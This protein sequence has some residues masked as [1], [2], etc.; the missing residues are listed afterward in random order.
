MA[1]N[2]SQ[3]IDVRSKCA[4]IDYLYGPYNSVEDA[5]A[6]IVSSRRILG[7]TVGILSEE[8]ITE[9]W[10]K[11]NITDS[12]LVKKGVD[13]PSLQYTDSNPE[14][15]PI[16]KDLGDVLTI[17][18][19]FKSPNFGNCTLTVRG[20]NTVR[21]ITSPKGYIT[22][23][24]GE[25][26]TEGT[27]E[28]KITGVDSIGQGAPEELYFKVIAGGIKL[29]TNF[30][31][32]L[33]TGIN[34]SSEISMLYN[35]SI[36]DTSKTIKVHGEII[37]SEGN[38]VSNAAGN[39]LS[40]TVQGP[41]STPYVITA[42]T[43]NI[44]VIPNWGY[45]TL[46]IWAFTGNTPQDQSEDEFTTNLEYQFFLLNANDFVLS[47]SITDKTADTNTVV[48]VP[49][50]IV[51]GGEYNTLK[52]HGLLY[53]AYYNPSTGRW[54]IVDEASP[55]DGYELNSRYP[56]NTTN[57]WALGKIEQAGDYIIKM[58]AT[59]VE[60]S[61]SPIEHE[62]VEIHTRI[63][64]YITVYDYVQDGLIGDFRADG[65]SNANPADKN[66]IW[67]N[68]VANSNL[69][70]RLYGLN[71]T[72][73]GW[74]NVDETKA[75]SEEGEK[76]LKFTGES[77]GVLMNG[78]SMYNPLSQINSLDGF[79]AEIV[80]RTR[81]IGELNTKVM[82][83]HIGNST[84][85][86][87][88]SASYDKLSVGNS[89]AQINYDVSE[90]EWIHATLV[91]DK[92][93]HTEVDDVQD[94]APTKLMTV[95]VDGAMCT[96]IILTE[97]MVFN[98]FSPTV[99]LNSAFNPS[100]NE[101][102]YFGN[103][104]I[105]SI[106]FYNRALRASEVNKNYLYFSFATDEQRKQVDGRNGDVLPTV[107]FVK[108]NGEHGEY[109]NESFE[110]LNNVKEKALQKLVVVHGKIYYK[111]PVT[112][113]EMVE[114]CIIQTQGTSSL[115]Y[116]VKNY[117]ITIYTD[118][119]FTT[120]KKTSFF[121]YLGWQPESKFTL[122]CDYMEAAHLNNT[123]SC[124]FYNDMIDTLV[125]SGDIADGWNEEHTVYTAIN[126]KR[127]PSRRDGM[128]DA[129][130]GFP[131]VV[132]Y[133]NS[134]A[135][136]ANN[137]GT[138]VG[139][140]MFNIDKSGDSLGFKS[141]AILDTDGETTIKITNPRADIALYANF[142]STKRYSKGDR[143]VYNN[144]SYSAKN[145]LEAGAWD[146]NNWKEVP[147]TVKNI[148]QS[149]EGVANKTNSAGCFFS[150][151]DY[152]DSAYHDDYCASA[153][154]Y[155]LE[156]TWYPSYQSEYDTW[157]QSHPESEITLKEWV[158]ER[159]PHMNLDTFIITFAGSDNPYG[160]DDGGNPLY[161]VKQEDYEIPYAN[162]YDY[163]A[164]DYE[165]RYDWDDLEKGGEEFWGNDNWGFERMLN[166]VSSSAKEVMAIEMPS[167]V[168]ISEV[169]NQYKA[170][171]HNTSFYKQFS[172]YFDFEY[173]AIYYLQMIVFGQVDN[174][175]KNSMWDTWD[176]LVW[177]PRPYDLDTATGLDNTGF[178][179]IGTDAELIRAL[180]PFYNLNA[181]SV[182]S[183][184]SEDV[185]TNANSRYLAYNTRTSRFWIAFATAFQ[186]EIAAFYGKLRDS[187]I[188]T[189]NFITK[190]YIGNTSDIIGEVYYN[191]DM[192]TKFYKLSN[193]QDYI[194][195]MHGNRK[196]KFKSWMRER[197]AFCDTLFGYTNSTD[198]FN[199]SIS[200]RSDAT[201]ENNPISVYLAVKTY[202]P[203]YIRITV[204][205]GRDAIIEG[206]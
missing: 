44:G 187:G 43:W 199:G 124:I 180:S 128:F 188:Y 66:G 12:G 126:D 5:C 16:K 195:R 45:Y 120:K 132:S 138:Y 137:N 77:Y 201:T 11:E 125:E 47:S 156:R 142:D 144:I 38:I 2:I 151:Q 104:E 94:Y 60:D 158:D 185:G 165:A 92:T 161:L 25:V 98:S 122:K 31:Q 6:A 147:S 27:T 61:P 99:L 107:K 54:Q 39:L 143:V 106:R 89:S 96:A 30:E 91:I 177:R 189:M 181:T 141:P 88:F 140:Y 14:G 63:D 179:V 76:M 162:K 62:S 112:G 119:T 83:A 148:C 68:R 72:S 145:D 173:C 205:S 194:T 73:N 168:N 202:S 150:F 59:S 29:S 167:G 190:E 49:F 169:L 146:E 51:S 102:D 20:G 129:I 19:F 157:K 110:A 134:E 50:N 206:Y 182:Q 71:Y 172:N 22:I 109:Q 123:P 41:A 101:I 85:S 23:N 18:V 159:Y 67:D 135:D 10:W 93:I 186:D 15:I 152:C 81:C 174:A 74:K 78:D 36:A 17:T 204:G 103:C 184:Y 105:K 84:N 26:T 153:Y 55:I 86:S 97:V 100:N 8:G 192:T 70:F 114:W 35:A 175:G 116:P 183:G 111:D 52:A 170:L 171:L 37:D 121:E 133:F 127:T 33:S 75:D 82:T 139:T 155:W 164:A 3:P 53:N 117:K 166:W 9:Y 7:R 40:F 196:Q 108:Y 197:I 149:F 79:T 193:I 32:I 200:L 178:E 198:S 176:G 95:Y 48:S 24:L 56:V 13:Q 163:Y 57:Y 115:A 1:F 118:N 130:K 191:R 69:K 28:Y 64:Q 203:Q 42:Q 154:D 4:N 113:K 90:D 34:T 21:T 65:H 46:K 80:F 160:Y 136:L 58:W 87:G 131:C